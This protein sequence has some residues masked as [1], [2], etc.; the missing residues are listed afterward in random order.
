M[1][2]NQ[3]VMDLSYHN[4]NKRYSYD[5]IQHA[6]NFIF[7]NKKK[8]KGTKITIR[9]DLTKARL[10]VYK[11][12]VVAFGVANVWSLDG[13]IHYVDQA[14]ICERATWQPVDPIQ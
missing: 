5:N 14:V 2:I 11:R 12:A 7:S 4:K 1:K 6:H 9:E 13:R 8:L 3:E 10:A